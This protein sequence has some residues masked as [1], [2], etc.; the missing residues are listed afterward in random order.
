MNCDDFEIFAPRRLLNSATP[1]GNW[2]DRQQ[3]FDTPADVCRGVKGLVAAF[4]PCRHGIMQG[5]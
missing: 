1:V 5:G 2:L 3:D 4:L